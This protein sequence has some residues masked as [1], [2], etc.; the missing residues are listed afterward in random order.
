MS[1][2][3]N[4]PKQKRRRYSDA[5]KA[6]ALVRLRENSALSAPVVVTARELQVNE[7]TLL[8]WSTGRGVAQQVLEEVRQKSQTAADIYEEI[9]VLANMRLI[10]RLGD[11]ATASAIPARD[12]ASI[13]GISTDKARLLREQPTSIT[14][15]RSTAELRKEAEEIFTSLLPDYGGDKA[16]AL[17]ALRE[18]APTLSQYVN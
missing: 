4:K 11:D 17:A 16:A 9:S 8:A 18:V 12:L 7:R 6:A 3:G 10:E 5:E 14:E 15:S 13:S 2:N 1:D